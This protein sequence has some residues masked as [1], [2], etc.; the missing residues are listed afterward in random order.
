V[1]VGQS[2]VSR[3]AAR[4]PRPRLASDGSAQGT[5]SPICASQSED[6]DGDSQG[7]TFDDVVLEPGR[8]KVMSM[9]G[10]ST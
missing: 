3:A 2:S 6:S 1:P 4:L 5:V 10:P 7:L 8:S 9:L